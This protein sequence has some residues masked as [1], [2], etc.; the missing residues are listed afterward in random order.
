MPAAGAKKLVGFKSMYKGNTPDLPAAGG[1][2]LGI[3]QTKYRKIMYFLARRR[4]K[5]FGVIFC[6]IDRSAKK[7]YLSPPLFQNLVGEGGG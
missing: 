1:K 3:F 2:F 7:W 5:F 6:I 4:R